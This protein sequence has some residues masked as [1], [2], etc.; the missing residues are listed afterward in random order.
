MPPETKQQLDK[1]VAS[2][3][4]YIRPIRETSEEQRAREER[5]RGEA[6]GSA[7]S[8]GESAR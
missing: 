1:L 3:Q 8:G 6:E 5:E 4:Q 7:T 2:L